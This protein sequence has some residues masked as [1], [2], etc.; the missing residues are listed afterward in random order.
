MSNIRAIR[1]DAARAH[2]G[3]LAKAQVFLVQLQLAQAIEML[4]DAR[5]ALVGMVFKRA[6]LLLEMLG[7]DEQPFTPDNGIA[8]GHGW[9][10]GCGGR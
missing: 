6:G 1:H 9:D 10:L 7:L 2:D 8:G 5:D 4:T 3:D